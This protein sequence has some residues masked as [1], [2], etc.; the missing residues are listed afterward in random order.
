[1]LSVFIKNRLFAVSM[2]LLAG[3]AT[4][5]GSERLRGD[6]TYGHE[7][8]VFC[9]AINSQCYWLGP[10]SSQSARA[11][12]KQ[13]YEDGKPGLYEPVCVV[14]EGVTGWNSARPIHALHSDATT[15]V[16]AGVDR[17]FRF[18]FAG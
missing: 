3:C 5:A 1:L 8:N 14:V 15:G 10:N 18:S 13:I 7:V 2:A 6:Y 4:Q 12:L 17:R 16:S 11:K 9:P